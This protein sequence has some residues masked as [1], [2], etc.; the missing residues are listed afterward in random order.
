MLCDWCVQNLLL[1]F[2][3]DSL[4]FVRDVTMHVCAKIGRKVERRRVVTERRGLTAPL[5]LTMN[6]PSSATRDI[7]EPLKVLADTRQLPSRNPRPLASKFPGRISST[8]VLV[9]YHLPS[10]YA[11]FK[12]YLLQYA[13][14]VMVLERSVGREK[15]AA[16]QLEYS[17]KL[18]DTNDAA[19][20]VRGLMVIKQTKK[21]RAKQRKQ[22]IHHWKTIGR[23]VRSSTCSSRNFM[24][25][26]LFCRLFTL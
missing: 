14:I 21:T 17:I 22:A 4:L 24:T 8:V 26:P 7:C 10:S 2:R 13:Q 15:L 23:K 6:H 5:S 20:E 11:D 3:V 19:L 16:S 9:V 12:C 25:R 1:S 18:N